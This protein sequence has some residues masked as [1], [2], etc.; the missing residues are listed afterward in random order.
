M[1]IAELNR[2]VT[3]QCR[4]RAGEF[5]LGR[6]GSTMYQNG[7]QSTTL[8]QGSFDLDTHPVVWEVEAPLPAGLGGR[9]PSWT[10]HCDHRVTSVQ[11]RL[12]SRNEV[13]PRVD[14]V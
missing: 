12:H 1:A 14:A 9:E 8:S 10:D 11:R 5:A 6:H 3:A 2:L 13:Q 4:E 7:N